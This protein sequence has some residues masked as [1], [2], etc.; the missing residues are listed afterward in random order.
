VN[1]IGEQPTARLNKQIAT[2]LG[3]SRVTVK[4]HR[5]QVM[6]KMRAESL[7]DLVRMVRR[8]EG[9]ATRPRSSL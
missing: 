3:T 1:A 5:G 2:E 8:A 7:A 6:C 9:A 4:I